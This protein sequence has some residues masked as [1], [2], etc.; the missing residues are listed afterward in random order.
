MF[1][2]SGLKRHDQADTAAAV[3][4]IRQALHPLTGSTTDLDPLLDWVGDARL[5]L[6][7][8]ASHGTHEFYSTRA[9]ITLRL[10]R[11]KGF[12]AVA[13]EA[14]WPDAH[15]INCYIRGRSTDQTA[16]AALGDF[17]RFPL[18]M[19]RNTSV[20]ELVGRLRA[21]NDSA[22]NPSS[23]VGFY[24][25]D[26]Y[27]LH[28]SVHAVLGYLRRIDPEAAV[29]ARERY[30]CFDSYSRDP[31]VY[32]QAV[33]FQVKPSCEEEVVQQLVELRQQAFDYAQRDGRIANDEFFNA[34]MNARLVKNAEQYYRS[35][36]QG[37]Q[38][39]WNL[40]D[41]HMA[42]TLDSLL[43]HLE[44]Q[45]LPGK[46]VVWAHNSHL[47][48]ARHTEMG[49][50]GELNLGQLARERH[51]GK[52]FIA[53]F[54]T[55]TGTVTAATNWDDAAQQ[56]VVRPSLT[57]SIENV[58][59]AV[60]S[61]RCVV[62]LH[63]SGLAEA[64]PQRLLERAIGVIYRPQSERASHYFYANVPAQFDALI[65]IDDTTAVEPLDRSAGWDHGELPDTY[66]SGL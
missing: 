53:G 55:H 33:A 24:G 20:R 47:G 43:A 4:A 36:F 22:P 49:E 29:R 56:K 39:T 37:R 25:L 13:V 57:N 7:G 60:G 1:G 38:S 50:D 48:D 2:L 8:E 65:H 63:N 12:N 62:H 11:E 28:S 18:W 66:P 34:E 27:S 41:T 14:D 23:Q 51:P 52:S 15:R 19:W 45:G 5:V 46:V 35:M 30:S 40:R 58:M 3:E 32:G 6:L 17:Q 44:K 26:L 31:Q 21:H 64:I 59:H 61:P 54:T 16:E 9:D 10:I 42:D